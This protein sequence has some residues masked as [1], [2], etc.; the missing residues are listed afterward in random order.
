MVDETI[1][2]C[3]NII[4]LS[5]DKKKACKS[6]WSIAKISSDN[7]QCDKNY[8]M[9][10]KLINTNSRLPRIDENRNSG[11]TPRSVIVGILWADIDDITDFL[12]L[13]LKR[14]PMK[15]L[16]FSANKLINDTSKV[17]LKKRLSL[18]HFIQT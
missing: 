17:I 3:S 8:V 7:R 13:C 10:T 4:D 5:A 14:S 9:A 12:N 11:I 16:N 15:I 2:I 1:N 6:T 18:K